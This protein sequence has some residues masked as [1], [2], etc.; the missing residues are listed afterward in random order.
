MRKREQALEAGVPVK[1][2]DKVK[3]DIME[4]TP[5]Q[6]QEFLARKKL[7]QKR[8]MEHE[9][10]KKDMKTLVIERKLPLAQAYLVNK[11]YRQE[12][13]AL[14]TQASETKPPTVATLSLKDEIKLKKKEIL[15]ETGETLAFK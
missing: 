5:Q 11:Q 13:A 15:A 14:S 3:E 2:T 4:M 8:Q 9:A 6:K 10:A 1:G 12:Q 7:E